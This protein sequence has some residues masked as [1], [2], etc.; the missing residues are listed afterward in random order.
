MPGLPSASATATLSSRRLRPRRW[1]RSASA[2]IRSATVLAGEAEAVPAIPE[3]RRAPECGI[4]ITA[5]HDRDASGSYRLRVDQHRFELRE[6][7]AE[8]G[9]V[10]GPQRAHGS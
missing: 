10:I 1:H 5:D 3:G 9:D 8:R 6:L 2:V 7:A 4:A